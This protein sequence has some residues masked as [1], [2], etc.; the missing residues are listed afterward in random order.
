[1]ERMVHEGKER[2]KI[3]NIANGWD[4]FQ[5]AREQPPK[6]KKLRFVESVLVGK[7]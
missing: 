2:K 7:E 4:K 3:I 1:M 6:P 5:F